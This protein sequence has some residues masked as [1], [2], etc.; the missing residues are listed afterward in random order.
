MEVYTHVPSAETRRALR[1]LGTALGGQSSQEPQPGED[2][3]GSAG[4][5]QQ[6][7]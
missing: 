6:E 1:K 5:D 3:E 7:S 2:D 4:E